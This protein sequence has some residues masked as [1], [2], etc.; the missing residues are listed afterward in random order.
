MPP[1]LSII[2]PARNEAAHLAEMVRLLHM[3]LAGEP[4]NYEI[5][6]VDDGSTDA[7]YEL[8]R[9]LRQND[10]SL[11]LIR[12]AR[13]FGKEAALS[14]GLAAA[15]G[16]A[17]V[18]MDCDLQHPPEILPAMLNAWR[19]GAEIVR[20]LR[21][22]RNTDGRLRRV[23]TRIY[24]MMMSRLSEIEIPPGACDYNLYDRKVIDA[25]RR[26]PERNRYMKGLVSW[27]GFQ[28]VFV[29]MVMEARRHGKS[30]FSFRQLL[31]FALVGLTA[32]SNAPLKIWSALGVLLSLIALG[33][34]GYLTVRTW[35]FGIDVPG[36]ASL[37]AAVLLLGGVQ[38][39]S[40]GVIGEYL[41]RVFTEV[42][43]RPLYLEA[44]RE[45]FDD[46][47]GR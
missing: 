29:P 14:C 28:C 31:R 6:I 45:G 44:A 40:L 21:Q 47:P 13:N 41:G 27:V 35:L 26:L 33:Y 5:I 25:L 32:F 3:V 7:T 9:R 34:G 10:A 46:D 11:R 23:L 20:A 4:E 38:L 39:I 22:N 17:A 42:K 19:G 24:Y 43:A 15:R 1:Q 37:M 2:L 16:N 18:T 8:L 36:Y 30:R 12:L